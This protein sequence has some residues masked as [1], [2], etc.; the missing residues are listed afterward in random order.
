V[1]R[2]WEEKAGILKSN[3]RKREKG[4][5]RLNRKGLRLNTFPRKAYWADGEFLN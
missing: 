3:P 5:G 1:G 2:D 4:G